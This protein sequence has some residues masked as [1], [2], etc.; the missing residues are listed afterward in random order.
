MALNKYKI[1]SLV[2]LYN[3]KCK[4]PNL[5]RFEVSGVNRDKEFFEPSQS[6]GAD[7]SNYKVVPPNY[8]A[9][10]LMHVGR[11]GVLPIAYNHSEKKKYVSPAYTVFKLT[12]RNIILDNYFFIFLKSESR[13][14]FF[15]F[16]T[17]SPY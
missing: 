16:L 8:F 5:S 6:V 13:D 4:I 1:G 12:K 2:E 17:D 14:R 15:L 11:D 3:E 10:N 9:C 7:T